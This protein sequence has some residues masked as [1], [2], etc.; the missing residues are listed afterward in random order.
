[1]NIKKIIRSFF[2]LNKVSHIE[3]A[4]I[5]EEKEHQLINLE[6]LEYLVIPQ[7]CFVTCSRRPDK[8]PWIDSIE[9]L[10]DRAYLLSDT[11][12]QALDVKSYEDDNVKWVFYQFP[13]PERSKM[14]YYG[15][16]IRRAG[17]SKTYYTLDRGADDHELLFSKCDEIGR[18]VLCHY[19]GE[20]TPD[21]FISFV[22]AY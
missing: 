18:T 15:M 21:A 3:E 6:T 14:A 10:K 8:D 5:Q 16:M 12:K 17:G 13:Q 4:F 7:H 20:L 19:E 2:G 9:L 22:L 11:D 1:M